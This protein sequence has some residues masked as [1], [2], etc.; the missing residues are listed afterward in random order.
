VR[1]N[2]MRGVERTIFT[3]EYLVQFA[4]NPE[5]R[6]PVAKEALVTEPGAVATGSKHSTPYPTGLSAGKIV[7]CRLNLRSGRYHSRFCND[8]A[9]LRNGINSMKLHHYPTAAKSSQ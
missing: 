3:A 6:A 2:T 8:S 7:D 5:L 1:Q 9:T 4:I